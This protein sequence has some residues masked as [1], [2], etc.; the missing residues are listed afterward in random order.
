MEVYADLRTAHA[1]I[2]NYLGYYDAKRRHSSLAYLTPREF[3]L[4][5]T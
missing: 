5:Q 1:E 2:R 3:E 4:C